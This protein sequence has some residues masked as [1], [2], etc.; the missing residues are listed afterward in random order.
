MCLRSHG[1]SRV[2]TLPSQG[3]SGSAGSPAPSQ[4]RS[5]E[6]KHRRYLKLIKKT[7]KRARSELKNKWNVHKYAESCLLGV[8]RGSSG[9]GMVNTQ[10]VTRGVE[11]TA[12]EDL[13]EYARS[14]RNDDVPVLDGEK[15]SFAEFSHHVEK[16]NQPCLIQNLLRHWPAMK[17]W[18][19]SSA[20][21]SVVPKDYGCKV[22]SDDDGYAVRLPYKQFHRYLHDPDQGLKDDS[23]LYIFDS[24]MLRKTN[25]TKEYIVPH[26]FSEDLLKHAGEDRRP[27]Y[28][29]VCIGGARSGTGI[30]VD[31]L[32]TSAWNALITG[33]KRWALFPPESVPKSVL[34]PKGVNSAVRWFDVVWPQTQQDSWVAKGYPRPIDVWQGPGE[35]MFVP[36]GW[37]HVV[38]NLD[39]TVAVTHNFCS[40]SNFGLVFRHTR[41]SRPKMSLRWL[42]GLRVARPDLYEVGRGIVARGEVCSDAS[43][44]SSDST[45]DCTSDSETE[46]E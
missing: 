17:T 15:L 25:M 5:V 28:Q 23:P 22:G 27:P 18:T 2:A 19:S 46:T 32:G 38:L 13:V 1:Q 40:T 24:N 20:I 34:K 44:P 29:W 12:F 31:P 7:K 37:W 33:H 30:H 4:K 45:S 10:E 3:S 35:T 14:A 8:P 16:N 6:R 39:F 43:S 42:E 11:R 21:K 36:S 9:N 26:L 41:V